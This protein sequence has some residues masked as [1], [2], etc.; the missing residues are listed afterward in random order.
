MEGKGLSD[1]QLQVIEENPVFS[2]L[3]QQH[4]VLANVTNFHAF[5]ASAVDDHGMETFHDEFFLKQKRC[6]SCVQI[7]FACTGQYHRG[8]SSPD[9]W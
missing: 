1:E 6:P 5:V 2:D 7:S 9:Q 4:R 8:I 3:Q